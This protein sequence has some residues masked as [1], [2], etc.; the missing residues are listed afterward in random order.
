[1]F[2][3]KYEKKIQRENKKV[4]LTEEIRDGLRIIYCEKVVS[5]QQGK[6]HQRKTYEH[7]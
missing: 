5:E 3:I 4:L 2:L 1:M 6:Q 7:F